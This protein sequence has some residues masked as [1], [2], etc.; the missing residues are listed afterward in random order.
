[1]PGTVRPSVKRPELA[2][3][4]DAKPIEPPGTPCTGTRP[5]SDVVSSVTACEGMAERWVDTGRACC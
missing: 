3:C 1:M 2:D 5:N 4:P